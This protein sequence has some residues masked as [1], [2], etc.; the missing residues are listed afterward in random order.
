MRAREEKRV[1]GS[2]IMKSA[3]NAEALDIVMMNFQRPD[4]VRNLR[5]QLSYLPPIIFT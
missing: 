2:N 5:L 4:M 1:T 3:G